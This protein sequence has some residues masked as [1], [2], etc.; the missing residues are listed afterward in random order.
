MTEL[1][2]MKK[3]T[4]VL[5]DFAI[6]IY[7]V[8]R[9]RFWASHQIMAEKYTT[10]ILTLIKEAGYVK[11]AEDQSLPLTRMELLLQEYKCL[12]IK[13]NGERIRHILPYYPEPTEEF[14]LTK[15]HT[16]GK[17]IA[18]KL[19]SELDAQQDMLMVRNGIGWRKVKLED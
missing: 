19:R 7:Q 17:Y 2:L 1:E 5:V 13:D 8:E 15:L 6:E 4:K 9:G 14:P 11:L 3:T 12:E 10:Q 16:R 18:D